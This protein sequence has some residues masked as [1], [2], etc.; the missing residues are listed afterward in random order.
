[1]SAL[2][3][4]RAPQTTLIA[5]P[6]ER[7]L[8]KILVDAGH[9]R[10][11]DVERVVET[12]ERLDVRFG[13]AAVSL[14][15]VTDDALRHA[16]A[17]QSGEAVVHDA[18]PAE[19]LYALYEPSSA[20]SAALDRLRTQLLLR[21]FKADRKLLAVVSPNAREGRSNLTANLAVAFARAGADTVLVDAD[22]RSPR[23]HELFRAAAGVGLAQLLD[24]AP[25]TET[26][27]ALRPAAV[28]GLAVIRAGA[29]RH[30]PSDAL[31]RPAFGHLLHALS[32]RH[33]VVLIDTPAGARHAD[34]ELI[35]ARA[36]GAL[37]LARRDRT[38]YADTER[39]AASLAAAGTPIAGTV[40][41]DF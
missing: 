16:L 22:M 6:S 39:L 1:V 26:E 32:E 31:S 23:Q 37:C 36:G 11:E 30:N 25:T 35:A 18:A 5:G 7:L 19:E 10:S 9:L 24:R 13:E 12:Q 15:L 28:P 4:K 33:D 21:W 38:R 34:A 40:F 27:V 14:Q 41:S 17:A 29:A 3:G 20:Y 8:G 2:S